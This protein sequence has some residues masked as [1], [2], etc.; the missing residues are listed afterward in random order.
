M[1]TLLP[2]CCPPKPEHA[3]LKSFLPLLSVSQN[4]GSA[5]ATDVYSETEVFYDS[6]MGVGGYFDACSNG[7][8]VVRNDS[9]TVRAV[10]TG[11]TR[12]TYC[13]AVQGQ[14]AL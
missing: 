3:L 8:V 9:V 11:S 1:C 6:W 5:S 4:C 2:C 13:L 14:Y 10:S 12:G 7:M